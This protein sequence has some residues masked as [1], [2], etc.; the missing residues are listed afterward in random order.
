M[1]T[2]IYKE[3][4]YPPTQKV[5]LFANARNEKKLKEWAFHHLLI[6]FNHVFIFDHLS[7]EPV[8]PFDKSVTI[9]RCNKENPV[10]F[11]LMDVAL[12]IARKHN[13]DWFIYLDADEFIILNQF[14]GIKQ[15]LN[16]YHYAHSLSLNWLMFGTSQYIQEPPGLI[17]ENYT[18]SD[19][20][21]NQHVKTFVRPREAIH[22]QSPHNYLMKNQNKVF[23]LDHKIVTGNLAFNPTTKEFSQAPA[24]I[25]HYLYQSEETYINRKIKTSRD[26][27]AEMRGFDPNIHQYHNEVV[28]LDPKNKYAKRLS[29]LIYPSNI[30]SFNNNED[31][32][33]IEPVISVEDN[34][35]QKEE[36]IF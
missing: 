19:L 4:V 31:S 27:N 10:K 34:T 7:E 32:F 9:I 35:E 6:G 5:F 8:Q 28:N 29:E 17:L 26:D 3:V 22:S 13:V 12:E 21:L 14:Q 2:P 16:H 1:I 36:G 23:N 30:P 15:M 11:Y 33:N 25:A 18:R 20:V 24:Y